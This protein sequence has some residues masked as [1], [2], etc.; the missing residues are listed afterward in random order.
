MVGNEIHDDVNSPEMR[1]LD[2]TPAIVVAAGVRID[3]GTVYSGAE[4][5]A[6]F[7]SLLV[8]LTCRGRDWPTAVQRSRRAPA[9]VRVRGGDTTGPVSRALPR[10]PDGRAAGGSR[11]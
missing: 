9:E 3:G 1:L 7:D 10:A 11:T 6:H 2:E 4:V 8:K 5:S